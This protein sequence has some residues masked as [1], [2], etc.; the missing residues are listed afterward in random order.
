M[1]EAN[2]HNLSRNRHGGSCVENNALE[3][4]SALVVSEK[5]MDANWIIAG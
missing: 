1:T 3:P 5:A 4:A 2:K